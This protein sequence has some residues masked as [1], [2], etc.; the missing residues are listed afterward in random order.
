MPNVN[1]CAS[2]KKPLTGKN[3]HALTC[4]S[5]CR[6]IKWRASKTPL[7]QL[8]LIFTTADYHLIRDRAEVQ[9]LTIDTFLHTL[10]IRN[11]VSHAS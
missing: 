10:A 3:A 2:C 9:G 1:L 7:V 8:K 11:N 6:G 4:G 5:T